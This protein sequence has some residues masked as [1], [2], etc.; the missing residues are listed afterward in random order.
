VIGLPDRFMPKGRD[1]VM[2]AA[3]MLAPRRPQLRVLLVGGGPQEDQG[4]S[5][6]TGMTDSVMFTGRVPQPE[7]H[8]YYRRTRGVACHSRR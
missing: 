8:R 6:S 1:L 3:A 7:V 4:S 2:E 5:R